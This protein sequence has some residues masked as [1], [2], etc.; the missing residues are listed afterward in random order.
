MSGRPPGDTTHFDTLNDIL[1]KT[2][3]DTTH[4]DTLNDILKKTYPSLLI[5][6]QKAET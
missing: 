5:E 6:K 3:R 1:K 4:F 2:P